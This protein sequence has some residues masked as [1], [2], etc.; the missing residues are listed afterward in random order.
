M[1]VYNNIHLF[2]SLMVYNRLFMEFPE[3]LLAM[4]GVDKD[5][6]KDL[7]AM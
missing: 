6:L 2:K 1:L 7:M 4:L 3:W 5:M